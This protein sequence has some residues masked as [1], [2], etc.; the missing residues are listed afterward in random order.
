MDEIK[1][2]KKEVLS[3][4]WFTLYKVTYEFKSKDGNVQKQVREIYDH[5]N[6]AAILLYNT[7]K[8]TVILTKQFRFP[9]YLNG[10]SN[11]MLIEVSAGLLDDD[12]PEEGI[13]REVEEETGYKISQVQMVYEA[14][15]I[16]GSVREKVYFF[17][18]EYN[19][20]MKVDEGGGLEHEQEDIEVLEMPFDKAIAMMENGEIKDGKTIMLLQYAKMKNL[21]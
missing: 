6:G 4:N 17:V 19:D 16:P 9:T 20:E 14:Y 12:S 1:I 21:L 2:L 15:M 10:N 8:K 5:G 11:G 13:R 7:I 3:D 18:A